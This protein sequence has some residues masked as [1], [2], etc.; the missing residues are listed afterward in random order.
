MKQ[1]NTGFTLIELMIVIAIMGILAT[2]ALPSFQDQIIRTQVKEAFNLS[3]FAKDSI[4][5]YYKAKKLFPKNNAA[6]GLPTPEKIIGNYVTSITVNYGVINIT[7]GNRVNLNVADKVI[8]I[9][10]AIIKGEPSV[11]IAWV[12]GFASIPNGM[13]V[14]GDNKSTILPRHLPVYCRY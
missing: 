8:S 10:P 3:E 2:M 5:E 11:P 13:I 7:L 9:R 6:A 14:K 4:E 1:N 12:Y